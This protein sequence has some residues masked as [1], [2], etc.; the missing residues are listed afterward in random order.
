MSIL[1]VNGQAFSPEIFNDAL[2]K[3]QHSTA[4]IVLI[5]RQTDWF[6]TLNLDYHDGPKYPHLER[7]EGKPDM[8]IQIASP[9]AAKS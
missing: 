9:K 5:T 7:I 4:P 6:Q 3:A 2:K 1:A 8:L